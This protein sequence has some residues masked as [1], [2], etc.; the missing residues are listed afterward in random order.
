MAS[1]E[2]TAASAAVAAMEQGNFPADSKAIE[3]AFQPVQGE[4]NPQNGHAPAVTQ[5]MEVSVPMFNHP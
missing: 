3:V 1:P 2:V 4:A 5:Q